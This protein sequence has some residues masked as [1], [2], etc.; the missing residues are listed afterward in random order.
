M[1]K[2]NPQHAGWYFHADT[3]CAK[4]IVMNVEYGLDPCYEAIESA[5]GNTSSQQAG[6]MKGLTEH[7]IHALPLVEQRLLC[8]RAPSLCTVLGTRPGLRCRCCVRTWGRSL[9]AEPRSD[10][11]KLPVHGALC[12]GTG[13]R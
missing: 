3:A 1:H 12:G 6:K 8:I 2:P 11:L 9:T 5:D 7:G 10:E 13:L 4:F